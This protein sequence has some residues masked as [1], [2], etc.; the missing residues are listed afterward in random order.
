MLFTV[1]KS[2]CM[3]VICIIYNYSCIVL[4]EL[5]IANCYRIYN[6]MQSGGHFSN[7]TRY[8]GDEIVAFV[9]D[10]GRHGIVGEAFLD[11][12]VA[13]SLKKMVPGKRVLDIGCGVG[14]WCSLVAQYGA[15]TVDG[16]DIQEEMVELAKQATSH[17]DM[18]HIQVGDV[19]NMPY[20]DASFDV[21]ISLFVTCNLSPEAFEKHFQ[22]LHRVLAPGGKAI[23]QIPTD[24]SHTGLYTTFEADLTLVKN[25]IAQI[26]EMVPRHPTSAQVAE[27]FKNA[28]DILVACFAV[29]PSGSLFHIKS[30][31]QVKHGQPIW[32]KT[33]IMMF[34]NFFY[35]DRA[36]ITH[37]L[38]AEFHIDSIENHFT[39]EKR[40]AHNN[41]KPK[42][43][44]K[45]EYIENPL[46]LVYYI[47]KPL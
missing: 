21:A 24:W 12:S 7:G 17:L 42:F 40:V 1:A 15:Q 45:K 44:L 33:E 18:V 16:F 36:N 43:P 27:A 20:D 47:S 14:D 4:Q 6:M 29:D 10:G 32:R 35:S 23:I 19:T 13:H 2:A 3:T 9:G 38:T 31:N 41:K 37:I 8:G 22:E 39:E 5:V 30:I 34:P 25:E 28:D 26:L 11:S 46:V